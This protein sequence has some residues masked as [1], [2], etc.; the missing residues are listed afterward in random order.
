MKFPNLALSYLAS[1]LVSLGVAQSSMAQIRLPNPFPNTTRQML[2]IGESRGVKVYIDPQKI[3]RRLPF[4][5]FWVYAVL[6][7]PN[8]RSVSS[9]DTLMGVDCTIGSVRI[10]EIIRY[11]SSGEVVSNSSFG[12]ERPPDTLQ[13][14][15]EFDRGIFTTVCNQPKSAPI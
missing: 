15:G 4:V 10:Y 6:P 13:I 8:S 7:R 12:M 14:L 2:F 1:S 3:S 9:L 11:D 5:R